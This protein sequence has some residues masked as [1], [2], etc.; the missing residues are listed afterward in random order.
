MSTKQKWYQNWNVTSNPSSFLTFHSLPLPSPHLLFFFSSSSYSFPSSSPSSSIF[1]SPFLIHLL[2]HQKFKWSRSKQV[3]TRAVTWPGSCSAQYDTAIHTHY[4]SIL[5]T[6]YYTLYSMNN[7]YY[8]HLSFV[9]SSSLLWSA[10]SFVTL[11]CSAY[12][13]LCAGLLSVS[14]KLGL[15]WTSCDLQL[16]GWTPVISLWTQLLQ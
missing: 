9:S 4:Y 16:H 10:S 3:F 7:L 11:S 14:S 5:Y 15:I 8:T 1:P 12:L 13:S 2:L 6:Q